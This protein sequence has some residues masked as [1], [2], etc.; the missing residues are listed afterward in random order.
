MNG[1]IRVECTA[2]EITLLSNIPGVM[3]LEPGTGYSDMFSTLQIPS[4]AMS[5]DLVLYPLGFGAI[6]EGLW[7]HETG[8]DALCL[9]WRFLLYLIT[10]RKTL[11]DSDSHLQVLARPSEYISL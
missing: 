10:F 9:S 5:V 11:Y 1:Q 4:M 8:C 6:R 2:V 3:V 7:I